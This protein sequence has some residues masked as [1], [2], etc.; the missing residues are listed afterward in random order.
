MAPGFN[1]LLVDDDESLLESLAD[2]LEQKGYKVAKALSGEEALKILSADSNHHL[3]IAD[4]R[5][6]HM[7]G[8]ELL[9]KVREQS[10]PPEVIII[11]GQ[12]SIE[13]AVK[14][15]KL[16]AV[17]YLEKPVNPETLLHLVH[18]EM[19][20]QQMVD[21]NAYFMRELAGRYNIENII[22]QSPA[23]QKV[24]Y[25]I[26][27][28]A[29]SEATVMITGESGT[30]KELI[31][32]HLHYTSERRKGPLVKVSCATLAPGV[33]ESE[34]FGH[35]RGAFTSATN[36]RSGRFEQANGGTLF[37]DE[38]GD[39]PLSFQ[40]KLLRVLQSQ[41]FERVGGNRVQRSDFRLITATN[42]NLKED[43]KKGTFREDLYYRLCVVQIEMPPL[44]HRKEDI[45]PTVNHFI[46]IYRNKTNKRI[47]ALD[48]AALT[49]LTKYDWPGNVRELKNAIESAF[50][51]CNAEVI[52]PNH[53]PVLIQ[54][55]ERCPAE[56][57]GLPMRS[58]ESLEKAMVI[59]CLKEAN[60]NKTLAAEML[61]VTRSTLDSKIK[62]H[63]LDPHFNE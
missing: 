42:H 60:G 58:L 45:L 54:T 25:Q 19:Q 50:V 29:S 49:L 28:L 63:N 43:I 2:I 21:Q 55:K 8:I 31:A 16:G 41:E 14:A 37:L 38:V 23:M 62:K 9:E 57:S 39:I 13:S 30:G 6:P 48:R 1:I 53:L 56:L 12:G 51:Y 20:R 52:L 11:T 27:T 10:E 7:N 40:T 26:R 22:G 47:D 18:K 3:I 61:D 33:L 34:L 44:R 17:D 24:F 59:L 35:E 36:S 46:R 5:L 15:I 32:N 4:L